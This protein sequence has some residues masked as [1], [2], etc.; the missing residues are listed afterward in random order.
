MTEDLSVD[1][2]FNAPLLLARQICG[3]KHDEWV[4]TADATPW[5]NIPEYQ[6]FSKMF[7]NLKKMADPANLD[8]FMDSNLIGGVDTVCRRIEALAEIGFNYFMISAAMPGFPQAIR[9]EQYTRFARDVAP[10][11]SAAFRGRDAAAE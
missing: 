6:A 5:D 7:A 8:G 11:F 3:F 1:Y 4:E 9:H 10:R 2:L